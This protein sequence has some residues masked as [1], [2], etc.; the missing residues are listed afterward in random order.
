MAKTL[1]DWT[2]EE[3]VTPALKGVDRGT[4][5]A[6]FSPTRAIH[7]NVTDAYEIT[8]SGSGTVDME[9]K[10]GTSYPFSTINVLTTASGAI[11]DNDIILLY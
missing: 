1:Q 2:L 11:D 4:G 7:C 10:A 8:F 9:L 3:A 6:A 5:T